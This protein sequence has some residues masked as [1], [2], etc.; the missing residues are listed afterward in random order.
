[1]KNSVFGCAGKRRSCL[2]PS[3]ARSVG[4]AQ[5]FWLI[6][7]F[8]VLLVTLLVASCRPDSFGF[9]AEVSDN[10]SARSADSFPRIEEAFRGSFPAADI[11][12]YVWNMRAA[13]VRIVDDYARSL[14]GEAVAERAIAAI[15]QSVG[16]DIRP[17]ASQVMD[18]TIDAMASGLDPHTAYLDE[19]KYQDMQISTRGEFGGIGVEITRAENAI[20]VVS[21]MEGTPAFRAGLKAG[22][23]IVSVNGRDVSKMDLLD[24]VHLMRGVVGT[25]V[26]LEIDRAPAGRFL[27]TITR[28][29]I[30]VQ[31]VRWHREG[32]VAYIRLSVF[33]RSAEKDLRNAWRAI[34]AGGP[35]RGIV[36]DMRNN[37]GG[38]LDQSIGIA[39]AFLARGIIVTSEGRTPGARRIYHADPEAIASGIPMVIMI[40]EGTASAAE[41]VASALIDN[42]RAAVIGRRSFGKGS[43]QTIM[44]LPLRGALRLTTALYRSPGGYLLQG[45]GIDPD[46][47]LVPVVAPAYVARED[48]LNGA[49][50]TAER[51]QERQTPVV[52]AQACPMP[53]VGDDR[54]IGCALQFLAA[55]GKHQFIERFTGG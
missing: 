30:N 20:R 3:G 10:V 19:Q 25:D 39:D 44:G 55:G 9:S 49:L 24:A 26:T 35:V 6:G 15:H 23:E 16:K 8:R 54:E 37:P 27:V 12:Q 1:M 4:K 13:F 46:V 47:E 36:L 45:H 29:M 18:A 14:D 2:A 50:V 48:N 31:P 41:I 21:P 53:A 5:E 17:D 33:V 52:A 32:D 42:G 43:V 40:N 11:D 51:F 7:L 34:R 22:D 28:A 38:L